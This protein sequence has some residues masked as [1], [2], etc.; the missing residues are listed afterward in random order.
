MLEKWEEG[1]KPKGYDAKQFPKARLR[2]LES[3]EKAR[4]ILS[5]NIEAGVNIECLWEDNDFH[6]SLSRVEFE[7]MIAHNV[8]ELKQV[9]ELCIIES[10]LKLDEIHS[11]EMMGCGT[12]IPIIMDTHLK[13]WML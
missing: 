10:G 11:I 9:M 8:E 12:R 7:E 1:I 5:A 3:I 4:I 6:K 2:M 13:I